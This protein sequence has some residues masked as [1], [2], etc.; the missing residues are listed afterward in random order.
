MARAGGRDPSRGQCEPFGGQHL[1]AR[2]P[3]PLGRPLAASNTHGEMSSS[4]GTPTTSL[5]ASNTGDDAERFWSEL[6]ARMSTFNLELHPEKTR[7]IEFGRFAADRRRRRAQGKPATFNFLGFT[8]ICSTT[9]KG[10]F[11]VRRKT[12]VQRLRKKLHAVKETLRRRMHWPIRSRAP[13]CKACSGALS[14]LWGASQWQSAHSIPRHHHAVLVSDAASTESAP[15]DD[16]AAHVRPRR[17]MAAETPYLP[18]VSRATLAR[19]DPRQEPGAVVPHAGICA[20]G[21]G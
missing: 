2:R 5:S 12:I 14:V 17:A 20:G 15:P 11:T 16:L 6:R 19:H 4:C 3:G 9:R 10:K 21:A 1:P 8:H 18:S 7:L 13:G